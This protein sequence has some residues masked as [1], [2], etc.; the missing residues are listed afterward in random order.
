M[1]TLSVQTSQNII[2]FTLVILTSL[3]TI[4]LYQFIHQDWILYRQ[5]EEKYQKKEYTQAIELYKKS[6]DAGFPPEKLSVNFANAHV[7]AGNFNEAIP[8]YREYLKRHPK[9]NDARL[10]L[11]KALS[12]I[13]KNKEAEEEYQQILDNKHENNKDK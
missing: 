1:R 3:L 12:W 5:A 10:S 2:Y 11:A 4:W 8:I 6:F 13:G 9:D 7:A